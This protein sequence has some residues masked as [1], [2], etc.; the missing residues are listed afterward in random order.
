MSSRRVTAWAYGTAEALKTF[1][2][3]Y[4]PKRSLWCSQEPAKF[5]RSISCVTFRNILAFYGKELLAPRQTRELEDHPLS[6][7][8]KYLFNIFA[9][10]LHIWM[11]SPLTTWG[12]WRPWWQG[13]HLTQN[14]IKMYLKETSFGT[15]VWA[16]LPKDW[17][18]CLA[19]V[20]L[21]LNLGVL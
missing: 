17:I 4:E 18:R 5:L 16:R 14:N 13:T 11:S 8:C 12:F 1:P 19:T 15:V 2:V 10:I 3:I 20:L 7:D 21:T 9:V 6:A